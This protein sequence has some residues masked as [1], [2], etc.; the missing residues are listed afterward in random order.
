MGKKINWEVYISLLK[1]LLSNAVV[2]YG[3]LYYDWNFFMVIY[4]YWF[5]ELIS[6]IFDKIRLKTLKSRGELPI[7]ENKG[8]TDGRFFFLF[9]YWVFIVIIVGFI[10]APSK[11][12]GENI[13]VIFFL[14]KTFNLNLLL[15]LL[16]EFVLC[17]GVFYI[18][19]RYDAAEIIAKNRLM[20]KRTLIMHVSIIF[21]TFAWFATNTDKFF[22][23]VD[24]GKYGP[25]GFMI[26]FIIIRIVGDLVGFSNDFKKSKIEQE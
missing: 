15:I 22:F 12:Y 18:S 1:I 3:V 17:F 25:F 23:H 4:S 16:G 10:V 13:L 2:V 19:K 24:I 9:L 8:Q 26:V 7:T 5:G 14:N 20:N 11:L 21:G 6:S